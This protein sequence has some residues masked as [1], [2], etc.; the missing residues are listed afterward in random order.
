MAQISRFFGNQNDKVEQNCNTIVCSLLNIT[1]TYFSE[2]VIY[3]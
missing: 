3:Q 2:I 1:K